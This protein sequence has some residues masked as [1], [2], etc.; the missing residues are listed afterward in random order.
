MVDGQA[1][2][3]HRCRKYACDSGRRRGKDTAHFKNETAVT[4]WRIT[5]TVEWLH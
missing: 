5:H 2:H 3:L 1:L 4:D